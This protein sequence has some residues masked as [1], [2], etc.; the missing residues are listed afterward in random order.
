[1]ARL[2][3]RGKKWSYV[4]YA[5]KDPLTGK[6]RQKTK[7]GFLTKK[8]AQLAAALFERE[9]HRDEYIQPTK[10]LFADLCNDWEMH[11]KQDAKESSLRARRIAL[12]HIITEY[13]QTSIQRITKKDYQDTINMLSNEFS[14]N[15]ISSIHTTTNMVFQYAHSLKLIKNVPTENIK[16]P[17][18][19]ST[20]SDLEKGDV[21]NNKFL[22]KEELEEFLTTARKEGL[23]S[24]L[25][26][27]TMLAYTGLRIGEMI[28]LKWSDID[29]ENQ[30]LRV[31][32]TY[33]NPT[34]NKLKYQLLTPK[35]VGSIRTISI[36]PILVELLQL[37]FKE[38]SLIK[39]ENKLFYKDSEFIFTN[40]E[41]YPKTI[42]HIAIRMNRLLKKTNIQKHVTPHSFRHTH[43]SLLIEANVHIKEIQERLEHSDISTTMDIYAHMTKNIKKEASNKFSNLMKDLSSQIFFKKLK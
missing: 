17:K 22:E 14:T 3:K 37:H 6:D 36:D 20:V 21:I 25:L 31:Y 30:T 27:F 19:K 4:C 33:Y 9:F 35:T 32:K 15:Y 10:I 42:K 23:E 12:K 40:N 26:A 16:L 7:S 39:N 13:G 34:N 41:G 2:Y 38:Q 29:F 43:T 11:Y 1:M 5:G 28:A 8:D 18:K 24:D